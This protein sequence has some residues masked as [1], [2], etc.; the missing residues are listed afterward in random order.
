M[1]FILVQLLECI[2]LNGCKYEVNNARSEKMRGDKT[3]REERQK[4]EERQGQGRSGAEE[5][6]KKDWVNVVVYVC[7][8]FV[9]MLPYTIFLLSLLT[10]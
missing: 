3:E 1:F 2:V 5:T 10:I 7:M 9:C 6:R 4:E 8:Y